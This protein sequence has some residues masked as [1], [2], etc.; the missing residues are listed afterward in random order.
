MSILFSHFLSKYNEIRPQ[1]ADFTEVLDLI[2][3]KPKMLYFYG[4]MPE[5]RPKN[6]CHG[7]VKNGTKLIM[8]RPKVLAVVGSRK[9]TKYGE[10]MAYKIA[11]EAA[12]RG[13][14]VVSGL[15]YGIDSIAHRAALDAGGVTVA[16]LGTPIDQIYPR[17]HVGLAEEI[18][19]QGGVV[20][21]EISPGAKFHP[22]VSFLERNRL[23]AGLADVVVIPEAAERSG[24]LNT[25]AHALEQGKDL[26]AVP[27]DIQRPTSKGCNKLIRQGAMPCLEVRDVLE[28]L[29]P[30]EFLR[31]KKS[32][33]AS[34]PRQ[35][36]LPLGDNE[37]ETGILRSLANGIRDGETIIKMLDL[38][39]S[40]FNQA[41]TM[42][43][44][45]NRVK[46]L[47]ANQWMLL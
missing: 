16:V 24:S 40:T 47:G 1:E 32:K 35:A 10:E 46:A 11:F 45:K 3:L 13:A 18:V 7:S 5:N 25:A 17:S 26:F 9:P 30:E 28:L 43:E 8:E 6:S 34:P 20:M 33:I 44:L 15:A 29:F 2:A 19:K 38:P 36:S 4:K 27:G 14:I 23:I 22:K 41:I 12:R 42:L 21:G 39:V 37:V 31:R